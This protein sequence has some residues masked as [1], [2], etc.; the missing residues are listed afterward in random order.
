[1]AVDP[2]HHFEFDPGK[3]AYAIDG[4]PV[5][6]VTSVLEPYSGL[7]YVDP[8]TLAAAA[9]FGTHVHQAC[10]L[11]N[12]ETLDWGALHPELR[13]YVQAW[14]KFLDDVGGVVLSSERRVFSVRHGYAGTLDSRVAWGR[15][16]RLVDIKSTAGV[17]RTVGPQTAAYAEAWQEQTGERLRDRYCVHLTHAG[18]YNVHRLSDPRDWEIFK[19]ALVI[20]HWKKR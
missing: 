2:A 9:E 14:A 3:H 20:H 1:M 16:N 4:R 11:Y 13:P 18:R 10:H 8:A 19:A 17:P 7:E 5:P 6:G 12:L 15:S